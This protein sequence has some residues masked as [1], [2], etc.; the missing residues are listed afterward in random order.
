[1]AREERMGREGNPVAIGAFVLGAIALAVTGVTIFGSGRL[2]RNTSEYILFFPGSVDGLSLGS[3]VKLKGVQIGS[4]IDIRL[5]YQ[6]VGA[7]DYNDMRIPVIIEI[8]R[9]RIASLGGPRE[10][11]E[12][13]LKELIGA[14]MRAQ[15]KPQSMVTGLLVVEL[16]LHPDQ[17]AVFVLPPG[18]LEY[19]E[20]PTIPSKLEDFESSVREIITKI[21]DIDIDGL[22]RSA[23]DVLQGVDRLVNSPALQTTV[24]GLPQTVAALN[25]AITSIRDLAGH[26][27]GQSQPLFASLKTTSDNTAAAVDQARTT[28]QSLQTVIEPDSPIVMQL[29]A[30]LDELSRTARSMRLLADYLERN[31]SAV[32]RGREGTK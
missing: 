12:I 26:L 7:A 28:L 16:N 20:I 22:V 14:G 11:G 30:T 29:T 2:F 27:D 21:A 31:P 24:E 3:P 13:S 5:S 8:D 10:R 1:M 9:D 32:V 17:P 25:G 19:P 18:S 6:G 4:V 15:L 23:T